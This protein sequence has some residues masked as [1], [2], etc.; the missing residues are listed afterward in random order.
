MNILE[1]LE[2]QTYAAGET[3]FESGDTGDCAYL[4]EKGSV[5]VVVEQL[6]SKIAIAPRCLSSTA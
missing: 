5:E 6:V 1:E 2:R 4:I 3:I